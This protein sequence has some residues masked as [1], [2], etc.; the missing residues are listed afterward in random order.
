MTPPEK[1]S[2]LTTEGFQKAIQLTGTEFLEQFNG[3]VDLW[4]P[5]RTIVEKSIQNSK[6]IDPNG[7]IVFLEQ[8]CPWAEHLFDIEKETNTVGLVK[9]MLFKDDKDGS[10][11]VRAV[12]TEEDGFKS[13]RPLKQEWCGLRDEELSNLAG[14]EGCIFVHAT[15]FIG[16]AKSFESALMLA[17]KSLE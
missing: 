4:L 2:E 8:G 17:K 9:Y 13:R 10:T 3:L 5:A 7:E 14:I 1:I 15:G 16:G 12:S 6:K 11:R